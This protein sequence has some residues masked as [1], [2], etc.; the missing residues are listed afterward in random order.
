MEA[1]LFF[2]IVVP[3]IVGSVRTGASYSADKAAATA[4]VT[5]AQDKLNRYEAQFNKIVADKTALKDD[6]KREMDS[7]L[8]EITNLINQLPVIRVNAAKRYRSIQLT[9]ILIM[10][11]VG[12]LYIL[13][14]FGFLH[15]I[16]EAI[17]GLFR[18]KK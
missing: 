11:F 4:A 6:I 1:G 8:E 18:G 12:F 3:L 5:Q 16:N 7:D 2:F 17:V 9:G 13:R 15:D 10:L 14:A